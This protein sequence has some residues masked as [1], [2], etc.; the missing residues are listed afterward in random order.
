M[1][2]PLFMWEMVRERNSGFVAKR[3]ALEGGRF[4]YMDVTDGKTKSGRFG[5]FTG[6]KAH[7]VAMLFD[8]T[9]NNLN[10]TLNAK[11]MDTKAD[12]FE[13]AGVD[14]CQRAARVVG[15]FCGHHEPT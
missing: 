1:R 5:D 4:Q 3:S 15:V 10:W 2:L 12:V 9:C 13:R 6:N 8:Y 11:F 14:V 7:E